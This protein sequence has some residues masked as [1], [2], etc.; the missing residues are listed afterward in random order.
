[1]SIGLANRPEPSERRNAGASRDDLGLLVGE[2][3]LPWNDTAQIN[4]YAETV[5]FEAWGPERAINSAS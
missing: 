2:G 5:A 1:M 4:V 3:P